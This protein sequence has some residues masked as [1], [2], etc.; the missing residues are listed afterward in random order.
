MTRIKLPEAI[1]EANI[2]KPIVYKAMKWREDARFVY[3]FY[4][5]SV[6]NL[7]S[8]DISTK[9]EKIRKSYKNAQCYFSEAD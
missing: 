1:N 3:D 7:V 5:L 6:N 4:R 8:T 2:V 9:A